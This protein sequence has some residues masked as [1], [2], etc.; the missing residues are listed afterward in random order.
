M[1]KSAITFESRP[2]LVSVSKGPQKYTLGSGSAPLLPNLDPTTPPPDFF[3]WGGVFWPQK[4]TFG[5]KKWTFSDWK[6]GVVRPPPGPPGY[7]P[8]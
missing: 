1:P 8:V 7:G 3:F 6:G 5:G 2:I 4:W